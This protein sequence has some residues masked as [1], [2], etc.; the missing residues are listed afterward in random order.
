MATGQAQ[1]AVERATSAPNLNLVGLHFHL[2][3]PIHDT[4]PYEVAIELV[5]RFAAEMKE[6]YG[7]VLRELSPGGGFD[8]RYTTNSPEVR[9]NSYAQAISRKVIDTCDVLN[10]AYPRLIVEPGRAIAAQSGVALYRVGAIKD[11]PGIRKYVCVDGGM[12]DNIRPALYEAQYEALVV[13]KG[14]LNRSD[15]VTIAGR[16]CESGDLLVKDIAL[17]PVSPGDIIAI[18]VSGAYCIPMSSNYNLVPRA[19]VVMVNNG[20][21]RIIRKRESYEDLSRLDSM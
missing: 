3:S 20:H 5:L 12:G 9:L 21:A 6:R 15:I 10:L 14:N 19:A 18:P 11:I 17:A 1:A 4:D 13:T 7:F 16:Y 2:G 8:V